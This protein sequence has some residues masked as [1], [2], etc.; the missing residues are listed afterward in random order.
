[1]LVLAIDTAT[2]RVSAAIGDGG[3]VIGE[4]SLAGGRRHAEQLA[5]AIQYL[6]RE[7]DVSLGQLAAIAVGIGPGLFTGLRVG[8]TTAKVMAQ[9]LRI[10]VVAVP[11]L[12]LVA[13]PLRHT[14]PSRRRGARRPPARGVLPRPY[15]PVPDGVQRV[16]DYAVWQPAELVAE[17]ESGTDELL[18]AG[19]GV[20]TFR[21][22]F[23]ALDHAEFA[24]AGHDAP[25]AAALVALATAHV[26]REEFQPQSEIRPL[27]LRTSDAEI[28]WDRAE[29]GGVVAMAAL[30]EAVE[31]IVHIQAMRRRHVRS[32]LK[33]E[34]EVYPRPWSASLFL[35]ELALRSTRAYYVARVGREL[36]G[37]AG[38]MMTLDDGHVTTIAVDPRWHRHKIGHAVAPGARAGGHRAGRRASPSRSA[39]RTAARR[40]S[41]ASSGSAR[42]ASA[43]TTTRR[44]TRT[45][46]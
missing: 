36:V 39:C 33:I 23:A 22:E 5:P 46:S 13:Y 14:Q 4:V 15:R 9:A 12:D 31:P 11:S 6:C 2:T 21:D 37:Y 40:S 18:L 29:V 41:T 38:L 17:L 28:N 10:P 45:R 7:L 25:S 1:M 42:S 32:V 8:V 34:H 35:S 27:Y 24:G 3:A 19:D 44:S 43:R 16:S 20:A 26:E 30:P